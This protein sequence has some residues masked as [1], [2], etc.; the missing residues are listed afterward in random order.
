ME[1]E[2]ASGKAAQGGKVSG[3]AELELLFSSAVSA[4][5]A[6]HALLQEA[7][8]SHRGGSRVELEGKSVK[9]SIKGDDIVS[10]RASLNSYLRLMHIIKTVETDIGEGER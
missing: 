4:K 8:F 1:N 5:A 6:Y 7:D 2:K 9:V 10:L 3:K